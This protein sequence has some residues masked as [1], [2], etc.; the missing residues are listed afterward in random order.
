MAVDSV[1]QIK[2]YIVSVCSSTSDLF[3]AD[4]PV[5]AKTPSQAKWRGLKKAGEEWPKG[6]SIHVWRIRRDDSYPER[7]QITHDL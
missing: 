2:R 7:K 6:F 4:Y 3:Y 1:S 5:Y